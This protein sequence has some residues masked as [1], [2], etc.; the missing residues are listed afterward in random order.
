M[1]NTLLNKT[2]RVNNKAVRIIVRRREHPTVVWDGNRI[3][4]SSWQGCVD[5]D[6]EIAIWEFSMGPV[7][8]IEVRIDAEG[9]HCILIAWR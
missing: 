5:I 1:M 7:R 6:G 4:P 9:D 8:Q 3:L 2:F